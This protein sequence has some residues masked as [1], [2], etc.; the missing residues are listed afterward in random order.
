MLC[1]DT[2]QFPGPH[3]VCPWLYHVHLSLLDSQCILLSNQT[4]DKKYKLFKHQFRDRSVIMERRGLQNGGGGGQVK[5][6]STK[7]GGGQRFGNVKGGEQNV[8]HCLDKGRNKFWTCNFSH[9][10]GPLNHN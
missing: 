3:Y 9:S 2:L 5:F 8:L 10:V 1:S 7:M 4:L 6:T